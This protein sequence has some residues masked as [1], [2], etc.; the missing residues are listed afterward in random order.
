[1][2]QWYSYNTLNKLFNLKKK[3]LGDISPICGDIDTLFC[4]SDDLYPGFQSQGGSL[5]C[6]LPHLC[7]IDSSDSP[8]CNTCWPFDGQHGGSAFL[9]HLLAYV[10]TSIGKT[11]NLILTGKFPIWCCHLEGFPFISRRFVSMMDLRNSCAI[12]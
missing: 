11:W 8:W 6:L 3:V 12:Y 2:L 4:T 5:P 10:Y 7:A 9:I 1:M